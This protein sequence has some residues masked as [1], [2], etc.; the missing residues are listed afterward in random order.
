MDA[1][2]APEGFADWDEE[3][4]VTD[5]CGEWRTVGERA[6]QTT[7]HPAQKRMTDRDAALCTPEAVLGGWNPLR[8]GPDDTEKREKKTEQKQA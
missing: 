8:G 1:H 2:V 4:V 5:R 7:R 3:R 6:D